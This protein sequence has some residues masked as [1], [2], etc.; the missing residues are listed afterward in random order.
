ME[1]LFKK[2]LQKI[3][4]RRGGKTVLAEVEAV[5]APAETIEWKGVPWKVDRPGYHESPA[6]YTDDNPF[7]YMDQ[8][9]APWHHSDEDARVNLAAIRVVPSPSYM[10]KDKPQFNGEWL[11]GDGSPDSLPGH[12]P[13]ELKGAL[14]GPDQAAYLAEFFDDGYD[15]HYTRWKMRRFDRKVLDSLAYDARN[16]GSSKRDVPTFCMMHYDGYENSCAPEK[17]TEEGSET[18]T[19]ELVRIG[20]EGPAVKGEPEFELYISNNLFN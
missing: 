6:E 12:F 15:N 20:T 13:Q 19:F 1:K 4:K 2:L 14:P 8:L 18:M 7:L 3:G 16:Y 11:I 5:A 10:R 17:I 9:N